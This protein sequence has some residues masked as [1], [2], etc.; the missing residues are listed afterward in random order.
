MSRKHVLLIEL[1]QSHGVT[2]IPQLELLRSA[3]YR[4]TLLLSDTN[5]DL[6]YLRT[7]DELPEVLVIVM[8]YAQ[9]R[10]KPFLVLARLW[11][12]RFDFVVVNTMRPF[13]P[14]VGLALYGFYLTYPG[15]VRYL[16]HNITPEADSLL[17]RLL[18]RRSN[19]IYVLSHTV[20]RHSLAR[21]PE[22][23]RRKLTYF[24]PGYFG[25][26]VTEPQLS[27]ERIVFA[28]P[29]KVDQRRRNYAAFT[30]M[31]PVL[32]QD[33][34]LCAAVEFHIMGDYATP[35]G[36]RLVAEAERCDLLGTVVILQDQPFKQYDDYAVDLSRSH[37]ILSLSDPS[38]EVGAKYNVYSSSAVL[39]L[40]RA[41]GVPVLSPSNI[42]L[43][44]DLAPFT[45]QYDLSDILAGIRKAV[46][47]AT[48]EAEYMRMRRAY[49]AH[50]QTTMPVCRESYLTGSVRPEPETEVS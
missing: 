45:I 13:T 35:D 14:L 50:I 47:L 44:P 42:E 26:L 4:V 37:Y 18:Q 48:D 16:A 46:T 10:W 25:D 34:A 41:F 12:R 33:E 11:W 29:G 8:P 28:L 43:D 7:Y 19:H 1:R 39:M 31:L 17:F 38:L 3:G 23:F 9:R 30:A 32:A 15:D 40:S 27:G 6:A 36:Q 2:V 22:W 5:H 21:V 49:L 20:Y 24:Y